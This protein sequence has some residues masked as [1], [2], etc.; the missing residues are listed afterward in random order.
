MSDLEK[1]ENHESADK[2][3]N[4]DLDI[5]Q[6]TLEANAKTQGK[7]LQLKE[8]ISPN[9]KERQNTYTLSKK[10]FQ[11]YFMTKEFS[12]TTGN[13]WLLSALKSIMNLES[14]ESLIR[15]SV[16]IQYTNKGKIFSVKLPL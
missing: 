5:L 11:K 1:I 7:L 10:E 8:K 16:S 14:F 6:K 4:H 15:S 9:S 3:K 13:C 12:Q 2:S